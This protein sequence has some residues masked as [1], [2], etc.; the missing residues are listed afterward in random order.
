MIVVK[1]IEKIYKLLF[2]CFFLRG[3]MIN[4]P[5]VDLKA[6]YSGIKNEI[7]SVIQN[8]LDNTA[9]IGGA[10]SVAFEQE[11]A[12]FCGA[13]YAIGV[14]SGTSALRLLLS[15]HSIGVGDE[16]IT[17]P[18]TF[19]ATTEAIT[20]VGAKIVFADVNENYTINPEEIKKKIT[21]KTKAI[22][23]VHLYG[24]PAYLDAIKEI[25]EAH[26]LKIIQD[27]AQAHGAKY[28]GKRVSGGFSFYPGKNLGAY[29]DGGCITTDDEKIAQKVRISRDHGRTSK[30]EHV[31]EGY[32][33]RLDNL[34]AA[35]LRVKLK[36]LE[37]WTSKRREN[38]KLYNELL[39][40]TVE[41]PK[42][43]D[44]AK[45]VYHLYVIRVKQR[46]KLMNFLRE[47]GVSAG[48]HYPI[49]LHM[50]PAYKNMNFGSYPNVEEHAK[51]ILSLP[52]F[53]ELSSEQIEYIAKKI[54]EFLK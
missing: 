8:V 41:T 28:K 40:G 42:E 13:S 6:Q 24:Q 15:A 54:K 34:Q 22:L 16:V 30:Y 46:D 7:D 37:E 53:P 1:F 17:V 51:E 49:P 47:N 2:I 9:F 48:I 43:A 31:E 36:H 23:P 3:I 29:G 32:N 38:A 5:F 19:I 10:D 52:M 25:A 50:Q 21:E 27:C 39:G 33:E 26:D 20:H 12:K 11:F 44:Y 4:I 35:I 14:S 18:N 45:H